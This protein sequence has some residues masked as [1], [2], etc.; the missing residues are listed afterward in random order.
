[1]KISIEE[2]LLFK[3]KLDININ[4]ALFLIAVSQ[5][6][7]TVELSNED[8]LDLIKKGYMRGNKVNQDVI[9]QFNKKQE[10]K[11]A[12]DSTLPIITKDTGEIIKKLA[13]PF[14]NNRLNS[15]EF[16]R[17]SAYFSNELIIPF[18]F[19]FLQM[20]PSSDSKKNLDW[21]KQFKYKWT[22]V[23]LRRMST[24]SANKIKQIWKT[25]DIG[26]F[27]LGTY[28]YILQSKS[29]DSEK[30]YV[31]KIENYL[32]EYNNWYEEAKDL[33]LN[34]KIDNLTR[35]SIKST[36]NNTTVI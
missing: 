12:I 23:T 9:N 14:I 21:D 8:L 16:E 20:F 29:D 25:K 30:F 35:P 27:L 34:G 18:A 28:L 2:I 17:L 5:S 4:Q 36:N 1:M 33:L 7:F 24:G 22:G 31:G 15:R 6:I 3:E 19:M 32:K 26:L 11:K 13:L 10:I